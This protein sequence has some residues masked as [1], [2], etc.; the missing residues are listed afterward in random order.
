MIHFIRQLEAFCRLEVIECSWKV[1]I[2][3][4]NK[5]E[6]DLDSLIEAHRSYLDRVL[7]KIFLWYKT[8]KEV[9]DF[10]FASYLKTFRTSCRNWC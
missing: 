9:S 1:L 5:R 7:N 3:F 2:D 4:L 8:G 10:R 6:G